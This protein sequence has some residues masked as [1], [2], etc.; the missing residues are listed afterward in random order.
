MVQQ[1]YLRKN[2]TWNLRQWQWHIKP[3]E[4]KQN[5]SAGIVAILMDAIKYSSKKKLV[6]WKKASLPET[7]RTFQFLIFLKDNPSME[8]RNGSNRF[9][10]PVKFLFAFKQWPRSKVRKRIKNS[11][12]FEK[13]D[14]VKSL[15]YLKFFEVRKYIWFFY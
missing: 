1:S 4:C 5:V 14:F 11:F 15:V 3:R 13:R 8:K 10:I 7:R 9:R 6:S 12:F 2:V